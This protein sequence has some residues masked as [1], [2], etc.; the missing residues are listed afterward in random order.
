MKTAKLVVN[1]KTKGMGMPTVWVVWTRTGIIGV[2]STKE[3]ATKGA[4]SVTL[5]WV[6]ERPLL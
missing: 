2:Y 6:E 5:C 1:V 3:A 4:S